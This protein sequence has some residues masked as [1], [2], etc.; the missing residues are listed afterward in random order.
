MLPQHQNL[1]PAEVRKFLRVSRSRIY[2]MIEQ[3]EIPSI[4]LGRL[5]RI[6]RDQL[7]E[8]YKRNIKG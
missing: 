5:I 1:T 6:P 7:L 3:G 4:K 8:W 2:E